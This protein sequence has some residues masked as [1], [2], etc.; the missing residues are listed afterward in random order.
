VYEI[1]LNDDTR[2]PLLLAPNAKPKP[3]FVTV[4]TSERALQIPNSPYRI[5]ADPA[6]VQRIVDVA[7]KSLEC[8]MELQPQTTEFPDMVAVFVDPLNLAARER[9]IGIIHTLSTHDLDGLVF[10]RLRFPGLTGGFGPEMRAEFE[11]RYGG[12]GRWPDSIFRCTGNPNQPYEKGPRYA[13][14]MQ[15]RAETVIELL[16]DLKRAANPKWTIGSYV[17]AGWE[18]YY[19][20]GVN[21]ASDSTN[22]PYDW[23]HPEYGLAGYA[24]ELDFLTTGVFYRVARSVDPGV[25]PGRGRFTVEGGSKLMKKIAGAGTLIYPALYGLDWENS[26]QG[27]R[28][29]LKAARRVG[30]GVMLFDASY[31]VKNDWWD[32]FKAEFAN[33]P[34]TPPHALPSYP[35]VNR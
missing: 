9:L 7:I 6:D 33:A 20:V 26:E 13:E 23:T 27:L 32:I 2:V 1:I 17:G 25:D 3:G 10:D 8:R 24:R 14:W 29:A 16:R 19:E 5:V 18:T 30:K 11:R 12:V 22:P 4:S 15:F 35:R 31:V 21:Y 34:P 28:D